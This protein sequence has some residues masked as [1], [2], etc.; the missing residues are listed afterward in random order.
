MP[1]YYW[2]EDIFFKEKLFHFYELI[3]LEIFSLIK[4]RLS[5]EYNFGANEPYS[6]SM[7]STSLLPAYSYWIYF[8]KKIQ[9]A[10]QYLSC[11]EAVCGWTSKRSNKPQKAYSPM[12][13]TLK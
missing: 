13:R 9:P 4:R 12:E 5:N 3:F 7:L 2:A 1:K 11:A 8:V 6:L 10:N